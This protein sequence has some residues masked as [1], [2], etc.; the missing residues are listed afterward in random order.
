MAVKFVLGTGKDRV[1]VER[2]DHGREH[3]EQRREVKRMLGLIR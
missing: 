1:V 3:H 2:E